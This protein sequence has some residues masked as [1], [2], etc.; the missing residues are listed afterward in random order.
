MSD[1]IYQAAQVIFQ[2]NEITVPRHKLQ[3]FR[4][5]TAYCADWFGCHVNGIG[6]QDEIG[7]DCKKICGVIDALVKMKMSVLIIAGHENSHSPKHCSTS[8]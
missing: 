6:N 3:D 1:S 2:R 7:E 4:L 8:A 5:N